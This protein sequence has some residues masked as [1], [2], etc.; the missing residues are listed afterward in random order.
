MSEP[1][2]LTDNENYYK[3]T[4]SDYQNYQYVLT[5]KQ[6]TVEK[7]RES[8]FIRMLNNDAVYHEDNVYEIYEDGTYTVVTEIEDWENTYKNY[9][10]RILLPS[11]YAEGQTITVNEIKFFV[12]AEVTLSAKF[13]LDEHKAYIVMDKK[14]SK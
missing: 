14:S 7:I 1:D 12:Q 11:W 6:Y 9:Y 4:R 5:N 10:R 2:D 8:R 13:S 3:V